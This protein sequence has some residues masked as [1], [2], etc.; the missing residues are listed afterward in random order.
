[1]PVAF[2]ASVNCMAQTRQAN[3]IACPLDSTAKAVYKGETSMA[4][5]LF[6]EVDKLHNA[7]ENVVISPLCLADALA[8]LANGA[9]G[10]TS[11]QIM[12]TLGTEDLSAEKVSEV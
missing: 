11:D 4:Y 7:N 8:I 3:T 12:S 1:M 9:K 6:E 10:I 5:T 2:L